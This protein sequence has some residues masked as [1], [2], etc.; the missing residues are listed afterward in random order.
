MSLKTHSAAIIVQNQK[1][2]P[3]TISNKNI[4]FSLTLIHFRNKR[5]KIYYHPFRT[6][7][8]KTKKKVWIW[9]EIKYKL[10]EMIIQRHT[11]A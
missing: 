7:L 11:E 4:S 9:T 1:N 10:K 6:R 3:K 8:G 5:N 2:K